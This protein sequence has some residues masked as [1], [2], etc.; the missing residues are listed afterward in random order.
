[1]KKPINK[2][3]QGKDAAE[4]LCKEYSFK[5]GV[6]GKHFASYRKGHS[7]NMYKDDGS[8]ETCHFT[9]EDGAVMLDPDVREYYSDSA[10]VNKALRTLIG[11]APRKRKR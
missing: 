9:L 1:M 3:K 8:I 2:I 6:R 10:S 11:I 5:G 7:V 4:D